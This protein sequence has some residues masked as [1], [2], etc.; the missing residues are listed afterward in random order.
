MGGGGT[1]FVI[2]GKPDTTELNLATLAAD[3]A[4]YRLLGAQLGFGEPG[5]MAGLG[6]MNGDGLADLAITGPDGA[7]HIVFGQAG[8]ADIDLATLA[9]DSKGY[10]IVG[11]TD[12]IR[13]GAV[14]DDLNGDGLREILVHGGAG[15]GA[16]LVFGRTGGGD[17]SLDDV[18]QGLGGLRIATPFDLPQLSVAGLSDMNGDGLPE[19]ILGGLNVAPGGER[20]MA[21][22][23]L[24][25]QANWAPD[26][27]V[28]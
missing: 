26:P 6:D 19:T 7:A 17:V 25:G 18:S 22:Y 27:P 20:A 4:G 12:P 28:L 23:V 11:G 24:F 15:L 2:F 1:A 3:G 13:G 9:A 5:Q 16:Y 8:S 14:L 21:A 10:S